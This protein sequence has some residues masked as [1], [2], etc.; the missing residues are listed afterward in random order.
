MNDPI[1]IGNGREKFE[2]TVCF[3]LDINEL[4]PYFNDWLYDYNGKKY[5]N[6]KVCK[7]RETDQYGK[8]HSVQIDTFKPDQKQEAVT[9]P[10]APAQAKSTDAYGWDEI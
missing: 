4:K 5:I 7:K 3:A 8:T 6:L 2:G 9:T 1:Y 10:P